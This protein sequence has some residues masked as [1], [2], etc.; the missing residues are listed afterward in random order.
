MYASAMTSPS[1]THDRWSTIGGHLA[2][3]L[4]NTVAWRLHP[5]RRVDR[6]ATGTDLVDWY[7]AAATDAVAPG[8]A[9]RLARQAQDR[10]ERARQALDETRLLRGAL[11]RLLDAQLD[12]TRP[13]REDTEAVAAAWRAALAVATPPDTLPWQWQVD[14]QEPGDLVPVLALAAA[15][16]LHRPD[17]SA[18]RRC[19]GE[20]CGWWFLDTTR[21]HSRRWCDSQDCGNRA[22]VRS[23][24]ERHRRS[25]EAR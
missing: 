11:T 15:D 14:P 19:A 1:D 6:L 25:R 7:V 3:D 16:L 4:C 5:P 20:G 2:L 24:A 17:L 23:Y 9:D 8:V 21:N 18:L 22:R 10:P 13:Q 12:R